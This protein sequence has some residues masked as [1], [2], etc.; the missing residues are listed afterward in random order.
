MKDTDAGNENIA[1]GIPDPVA[2][3]NALNRR[4][5][6][7]GT[8][9]VVALTAAITAQTSA[10]AQAPSSPAPVP[11]GPGTAQRPAGPPGSGRAIIPAGSVTFNTVITKLK[12][13]KQIFSNTILQPDLEAAKKACEGQDF[14]WIEMQHSRLTWREAEDLI[15][16]IAQAGCIPFVR[17]PSANA[18][19]IQKA[20][21]SGALGIIIPMVDTIEEARRAVMYAKWPIGSRDNPNTKPW[22]HRSSG[23]GQFNQLW[24]P[25]YQSNANNNILV[26]I[27][28]ENP[29]GVGLIDTI[30]EEVAGIDIVMVA[31]NDFGWQAG[32][33]DGDE[34]YNAREK[35]VREAV[36]KHGKILSGPSSWQNRPGYR[37]FQGRRNAAN[38]GYD[39]TGNRVE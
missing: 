24:G 9:G 19:D 12:E 13:G 36:L 20:T 37:L 5:L 26:M 2:Q 16:V 23:G 27:Q 14:I 18:G 7:V 22:G 32:D 38:T 15:R 25:A 10:A 17:V 34:S 29:Q 6:L 35:L 8:A 11:P 4:D 21:D 31:S 33:R 3:P 1:T 39:A 28:I 30:L